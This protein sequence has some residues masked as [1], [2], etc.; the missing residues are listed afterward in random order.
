MT[1]ALSVSR[2]TTVRSETRLE[3]VDEPLLGDGSGD[4]DQ[5]SDGRQ[6]GEDAGGEE[7]DSG[8][9]MSRPS[10]SALAGSRPAWIS[11]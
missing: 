6:I 8:D 3:P 4:G 1:L 9:E 7:Q 11:D 5:Q 10:T 2:P